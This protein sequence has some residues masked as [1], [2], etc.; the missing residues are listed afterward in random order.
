MSLAND[1][2]Q[3]R[4]TAYQSF[5]DLHYDMKEITDESEWTKVM[6]SVNKVIF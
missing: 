3:L 4:E 2:N 6:K 1:M 5:I